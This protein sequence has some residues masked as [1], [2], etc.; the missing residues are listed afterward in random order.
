MRLH[1]LSD[2]H[3]EFRPF[4]L[5][6]VN[7]DVLVLAGDIG[8]GLDGV[9]LAKRWAE[10]QPVIYVSGNHEF[11]RQSWPEHLA[12]MHEISGHNLYVLNNDIA[13]IDGVRFLGC[14]LW[15]DFCLFGES[16]E[17]HSRM[18]AGQNMNDYRL[19]RRRDGHPITPLDTQRAH[20]ESIRWLREQLALPFGGQTV[21]VSHHAP[22]QRSLDPRFRTDD[23][24]NPAYASNLDALFGSAVALWVHGHTHHCVDYVQNSTRVVSNARGY[25][26][27]SSRPADGFDPSLVIDL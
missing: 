18:A 3:V 26:N 17:A 2:L 8:V 11:Y 4:T 5:P 25:P 14:T 9:E 1:V 19:I 27:D 13:I 15:T 23:P 6:V 7:S 24:I 20:A 12:A 22:S 16:T 21:V 10:T